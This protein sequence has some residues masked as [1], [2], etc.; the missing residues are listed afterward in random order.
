MRPAN[1]KAGRSPAAGHPCVPVAGKTY[2]LFGSDLSTEPYYVR[3]RRLAD[4]LL[5]IVPGEESLLALIRNVDGRKRLLARVARRADGSVLSSILRL[6]GDV[7]SQYTTNVRTHLSGLSIRSVTDRRLRTT[8][9]Q[10]HLHMLEI[11][12]VNRIHRDRFLRSDFRIAL[13]PHCLRDFRSQCRSVPGDLDSVCAGCSETCF[14]HRVSAILREAGIHPYIWRNAELST[15]IRSL[16][17][18]GA[19]GVLGIACIPE[20]AWGMR[21]CMKRKIP[22][23]GIPLDANRCMRWMGRFE[24]TSVNL[25]RLSELVIAESS[26]RT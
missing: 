10:Y 11:E 15:L 9:E 26:W 8:E 19:F 21:A 12:L 18:R 16:E 2:S 24:E 3:V 20:L 1:G 13:L 25:E 23:V 4:E 22:V 17:G 6:L 7:L 14:L 5:R